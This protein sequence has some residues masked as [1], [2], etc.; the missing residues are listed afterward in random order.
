MFKKNFDEERFISLSEIIYKFNFLLAY[1]R[2]ESVT[3]SQ[4]FFKL[5]YRHLFKECKYNKN[6]VNSVLFEF[7][8]ILII[9]I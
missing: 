9:G 2:Y 1:N 8:I 7:G 6:T 4:L 3:I 5:S